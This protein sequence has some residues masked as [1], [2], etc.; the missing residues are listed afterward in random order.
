MQ[1]LNGAS[2]ERVKK[3]KASPNRLGATLTLILFMVGLPVL[4]VIGM[5]F[6]ERGSMSQTMS[7]LTAN[8]P[9]FVLNV[10]LT[11]CL[12]ALV[13][14]IVGSL[15]I[16]G[17]IAT[18]V[19]GLM[20]L[21]SYMKV[22]MIGEP[23]FPWDILLNKESMDI[24]SLVTG[25]AALIRIIAVII[26]VLAVLALR[27]V[28]PRVTIPIIARAGLGLISLYALY[29]FGIKTPLAS[30]VIDHAGVSEIVWDQQQNY[31]N[32]GLA[33]AFTLNVK[34]SIVQK[35]DT[36]NESAIASAAAGI[37]QAEVSGATGAG[38]KKAVSLPAGKKPN[39]I[40][41]MSEAFWDPTLLTNVKF[42][43]DPVPTIHRLQKESAT[44]YLLSPQFGGGTANVEFEVLTGNSMSFL[45]GGSIP[46]Q[47]YVSKPLPSLA[48][49][50]AGLGYK[51][52]G[53]HSYEGWFWDRNTVYKQ[54][55][56]ETFKSSEYFTNP[57]IKGYFISDAEVA[58]NIIAETDKTENPM[59]IYTV[60]MQNHGPYDEPRYGENKYKAEGNLS[61][62]AK[63]ILETYTQGAHDAD[64]S[65]QMLIDHYAESDEPTMLIFY[66]DHLPMLGMDYQVYKEAGFI[67]TSNANA[68]TLEENKKMHSTPLV[69]WSNFTMP[70]EGLGTI[71]ASFLGA[72]V[73]DMLQLQKPANFTLDSE[74]AKQTPGLLG[75]LVIDSN[76]ELQAK[77][78]ESMQPLITDYRNVQYDL[79]FGKQFLA[80]YI[81]HEYLTKSSQ[82]NY[83]S[84]LTAAA[85]GG[86]AEAEGARKPAASQ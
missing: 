47:Q 82:P 11:F 26:I 49:Y 75:N 18:A 19:L 69:M 78:P 13:Y 9:L 57:E 37:Q 50:F 34:N 12:L 85:D 59:F 27:W 36:Y 74:V 32:N 56:F 29:A 38:L 77:A 66:G 15:A 22:K 46:Y 10:I 48:S 54:L 3:K 62:Q 44:G 81:D 7:W 1:H 40:F 2:Q 41:I 72:H 73:L 43:E 45:P 84:E 55:G 65:L 76:G 86:H 16:S 25:K 61:A 23:F 60:T 80:N 4:S 20:A 83:N 31:A 39:V 52:M 35:P 71:S 51:S 33:L 30:K 42:S 6:L 14:A 68:W 8:Q 28:I 58:R 17:A 63:S 67:S 64:Q 53:I 24:A 79:M 70:K 21:I 5:E